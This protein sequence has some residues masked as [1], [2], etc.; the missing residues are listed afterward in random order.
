MT[1]VQ[2]TW[3]CLLKEQE[4]V[5]MNNI[6]WKD[7]KNSSL[8]YEYLVDNYKNNDLKTISEDFASLF[9][10]ADE[11]FK[12]YGPDD[13]V[14]WLIALMQYLKEAGTETEFNT[15][16]SPGL[17]GASSSNQKLRAVLKKVSQPTSLDILGNSP[18]DRFVAARQR[19]FGSLPK[20]L[21]I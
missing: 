3:C 10:K 21:L 17:G 14:N 13:I 19:V 18:I 4:E 2:K 8:V 20:S 12:G 1:N 11:D 16:V 5:G 9:I 6:H 15:I 7:L